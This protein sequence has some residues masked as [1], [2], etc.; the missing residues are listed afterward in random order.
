[1]AIVQRELLCDIGEIRDQTG[2]RTHTENQFAFS[3]RDDDPD[4]RIWMGS[5]KLVDDIMK[6]IWSAPELTPIEQGYIDDMNKRLFNGG[7]VPLTTIEGVQ[8]DVFMSKGGRIFG[9]YAGT[10]KTVCLGTVKNFG[11]VRR[12]LYECL[13]YTDN[14]ERDGS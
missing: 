5:S 12:K 9:E 8:F 11:A 13:G 1:M 10:N 4:K 14:S 2:E 3:H 7:K 6:G